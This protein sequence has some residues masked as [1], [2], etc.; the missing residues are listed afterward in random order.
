MLS[1]AMVILP[2]WAPGESVQSPW[3]LVHQHSSR[4]MPG[5]LAWRLAAGVLRNAGSGICSPAPE[6]L[7]LLRFIGS[8]NLNI[9]IAL[10]SR[11]LMSMYIH[12]NVYICWFCFL[13]KEYPL[14]MYITIA[15][16]TTGRTMSCHLLF[17]STERMT[18]INLLTATPTPI[19]AFS[20]ILTTCKGGTWTTFAENC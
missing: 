14:K 13:G 9:T 18:L 8:R 3:W 17:A 16:Q 5:P 10:L 4:A 19:L 11:F 20:T 12:V 6:L 2:A 1:P 7:K 15:A